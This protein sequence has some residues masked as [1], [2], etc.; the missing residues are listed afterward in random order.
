MNRPMYVM[1]VGLPGSGKSYLAKQIIDQIPVGWYLIGTDWYIDHVAMEQGKTYNRVFH[2]N[3]AAATKTMNEDRQFALRGGHPIVHDQTNLTV[4]SRAN[5]MSG[6]PADYV[7]IAVW[8]SVDESVRQARMVN[9]PGKII[10]EYVDKQMRDSEEQPMLAE[11]FN[12][13]VAAEAWERAIG[14]YV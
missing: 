4:K 10:P 1:L 13:V 6:I 8:C 2:D 12:C 14:R 5:K 7:K 9:R 3:I 11:G